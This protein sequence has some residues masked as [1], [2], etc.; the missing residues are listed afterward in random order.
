M[1]VQDVGEVG[2]DGVEVDLLGRA[3]AVVHAVGGIQLD[4]HPSRLDRVAR[5]DHDRADGAGR[6]RRD[7][8]LHLHRLEHRQ[9]RARGDVV[10][11]RHVHADD[12]PGS[13][14]ANGPRAG[15]SRLRRTGRSGEPVRAVGRADLLAVLVQEAGGQLATH[16]RR[17]RHDP[18][19]LVEVRVDPLDPALGQRAGSAGGQN[20]EVTRP[21]VDDELGQQ[22]VVARAHRVSRVSG[23]VDPHAPARRHRPGREPARRPGD[24][25]ELQRG[26]GRV[27]ERAELV[28]R[29]TVGQPQ[30]GRNE[31]DAG[32]LLGDRVF[33]LQ[34]WVDLEERDSRP[35]DEELDG[36][37][38]GV[39][40]GGGEP[41]GRRPQLLTDARIQ[42]GRRGQLDDLLVAALHRAVPLAERDDGTGAVADHLH[43]HV[44]GADQQLL[45]VDAV[46]AER[47]PR[48]RRTPGV[49]R[50][51]LVRVA[52][53]DPAHPASAPAGDRLE[54][55]GRDG[56]G[57]RDRPRGVHRTAR[58]RGH[59]HVRGP[60]QLAGAGLVPERLQH[61]RRRTDERDPGVGAGA[62]EAGVLGQ[63]PVSRVYRVRARLP[64][65]AQHVV[66][67]EVG[68]GTGS[69][70]RDGRADRGHVR[71]VGVVGGEDADRGD[72]EFDGGLRDPDRDLATVGDQQAG[73]HVRIE[74]P[75]S[76]ACQRRRPSR[77]S[78]ATQS[79]AD[80]RAGGFGLAKVSTARPVGGR[81]G[82]AGRQTRAGS[83]IRG[84]RSACLAGADHDEEGPPGPLALR[85]RTAG[86]DRVLRRQHRGQSRK[87][88]G[89]RVCAPPDGAHAR[90][91]RPHRRRH[92]RSRSPSRRAQVAVA[93]GRRG[94]RRRSVAGQPELPAAARAVRGDE[95][96]AER[97]RGP[98]RRADRRS[99][100]ATA[101]EVR[102][103]T[104]RFPV[105]AAGAMVDGAQPGAAGGESPSPAPG[106]AP[107]IGRCARWARPVPSR[108]STPVAV[109]QH[110][111]ET[112]RDDGAVARA[113]QREED[114]VQCRDAGGQHE[115]V[116]GLLQCSQLAL[117]AR[118]LAPESRV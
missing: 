91:R 98:A 15:G 5:R 115:R 97:A 32:D 58:P 52:A 39:S 112:V 49:R 69:G 28:Q 80:A 44:S 103:W 101:D 65:R 107:R 62:R 34:P 84:R 3:G 36:A 9:R 74:R 81:G 87:P 67:V 56:P 18:G 54:H 111:G 104:P 13:G 16:E 117:R 10:A 7:D 38:P 4:E 92:R 86:S 8:V 35:I 75:G 26:S 60:G 66:D 31:V 1:P 55:H 41:H 109:G 114:R 27:G 72:P 6:R 46:V 29:R 53:L 77:L 79:V 43:L 94:S 73:E 95:L 48:L 42:S 17:V 76:L 11:D 47:G 61:L 83:S 90:E 88:G 113:Q 118:W 96:A 24:D 110:P 93:A 100:A 63:E 106:R 2:A 23:R 59:R 70:E 40:D 71:R 45:G 105:R 64:S 25:A 99:R 33:H 78:D 51:D 108:A 89:P 68:R 57:E 37:Q 116:L 14:R 20:G 82:H 21:V 30:P 22:R 12:R 50:G 85:T 19:E 102:E